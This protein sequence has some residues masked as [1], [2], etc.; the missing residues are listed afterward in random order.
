MQK[1]AVGLER[2]ERSK[3]QKNEMLLSL[4]I[5]PNIVQ[6][7]DAL[8][9]SGEM[10]V[11][12]FGA[13]RVRVGFSFS[14][15]NPSKITPVTLRLPFSE[16]K[17][18]ELFKQYIFIANC[19]HE[20]DVIYAITTK[21]GV[22]APEPVQQDLT[23]AELYR[24]NWSSYATVSKFTDAE[25]PV[26][27]ETAPSC[28]KFDKIFRELRTELAAN[29]DSG[30]SIK[31]LPEICTTGQLFSNSYCGAT[32]G[33]C[34]QNLFEKKPSPS[35]LASVQPM[36]GNCARTNKVVDFPNSFAPR[37]NCVD[38]HA[39][40]NRLNNWKIRISEA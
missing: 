27:N 11:P 35:N 1:R 38:R 7:F 2:E 23:A 6:H 9:P 10:T 18:R 26:K 3:E 17:R 15:E 24:N 22:A 28:H 4:G 5:D 25:V 34:I 21:P 8:N 39:N 31:R 30:Y 32:L 20:D 14:S 13:S 12:L 36:K 40:F 16:Q 33:H 29:P 19:D 37:E